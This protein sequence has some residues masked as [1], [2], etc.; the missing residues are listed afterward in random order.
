MSFKRQTV[1]IFLKAIA[2]GNHMKRHN[3][4]RNT[5]IVFMMMLLT[6]CARE[7]SSDVYT[8]RQAG[9]ISTTYMGSIKNVRE[10]QVAQGEQLEENSL[11]MAGGGITGG[12]LGNSIGRGNLLPTAAGALAGAV[13]GSFIEKKLKQQTA[14]EYVVELNDGSLITV[15]QGRNQEFIIN[16]PVYVIVSQSGRSRI[17]PQ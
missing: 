5:S 15:V 3:I 17:T 8:A 2:K 14:L 7:I 12:V 9:E 13:A 11:G 4:L 6:S 10:V 16:Q 1:D